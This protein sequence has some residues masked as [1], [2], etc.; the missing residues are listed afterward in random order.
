MGRDIGAH[1]K[2]FLS[3]LTW[4]QG[5]SPKSRFPR[6]TRHCERDTEILPFTALISLLDQW[7]DVRIIWELLKILMS[8]H[9]PGQLYEN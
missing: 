8:G 3:G 6:L 4:A 7:F 1:S 5:A 9:I 2:P